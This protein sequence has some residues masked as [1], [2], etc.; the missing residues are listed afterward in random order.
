MRAVLF[1][2]IIAALAGLSV[3]RNAAWH[4]LL[5]LWQDC[6]RKSPAKSRTHNNV[7]NCYLL[8]D[9][10]FPAIAEYQRALELDPENREAR[11]NLATT[12]DAAGLSA[13]AAA[14]YDIFCRTAPAEYRE[15]RDKACARVSE[16]LGGVRR[17]APSGG[18][19]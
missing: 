9:R 6:A 17:P 3:H 12:L 18:R 15:Q 13:E 5:S 10:R 16:L 19:Q 4:S 7:G 8:L 11:Y 1:I 2:I 14:H